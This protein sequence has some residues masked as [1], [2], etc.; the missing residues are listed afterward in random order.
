M[1]KID[2][3][4]WKEFKI[5]E[6]FETKKHRGKFQVP[7]GANVSAKKLIEHGC[8]PRITVTGVNNGISGLYDYS[9]DNESEYRT[10]ENFISVS[11]LGTVFYHEE[12]A[13]LDM[14][15]HCL[16]PIDVILNKY[17]GLYFVSAIKASLK[18]SSYADQIS[19]T[20]L[21]YLSVYLPITSN[22]LPDYEYM[23]SYMKELEYTVSSSLLLLRCAIS[24]INRAHKT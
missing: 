5:H 14:K 20:V 3:R 17:T 6:L 1:S 19:S 13:S 18:D 10:F 22:N 15:V 2:T 24:Q 7:T 4:E 9:G 11:F 12:K 21:P 23:E 16:K 8:T